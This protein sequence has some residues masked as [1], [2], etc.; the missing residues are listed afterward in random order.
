MK[1]V[2]VSAFIA[3]IPSSIVVTPLDHARFKVALRK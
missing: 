1:Y 3:G 2:L